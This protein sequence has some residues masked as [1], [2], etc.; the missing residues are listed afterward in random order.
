MT[1]SALRAVF[2]ATVACSSACGCG[3]WSGQGRLPDAVY[4][5][6]PVRQKPPSTVVPASHQ[7]LASA[8]AATPAV[9]NPQPF[10]GVPELDPDEVVRVVL[11]RNPTLDQMQA[12]V[13]AVAA[14]FPQVTSLDDPTF[15]F[16]TAP[17]SIGSP[18][19]DYA[20]RAEVS[21]KFISSAKRQLKGRSVQAETTAAMEDVEDLRTQLAESAKSALADY[22]LAVKSI[23]VVEENL[24]LI[25]DYRRNAETRYKTGQGQQQDMLQADVEIGRQEEQLL[26]LRRARQVAIAR[27]NTLMHFPPESLLPPPANG[28]A[29]ATLPDPP[30][31]RDLAQRRPD[32]RAALARI[33]AEEAQLAFAVKDYNPD[34]ELM[35]AYDGFWQGAGGR[36]LQWQAGMRMNLP[37]RYAKR[38]GIVHEARANIA[39]R[40]AELARLT[41]QVNYEVEEAF[42]RLREVKEITKLYDTK[43][44]PAAESNVKEA[45]AGYTTGKIPFLNL[46]EA[47]RNRIALQ[48][49]YYQAL[50]EV[51]RR[52]AALERAVGG[53]LPAPEK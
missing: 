38:S 26:S 53:K 23:K 34:I 8:V 12:T 51:M 31:L 20:A 11:A 33:G 37:V 48:E 28:P 41:D 42:E 21:Q 29:I 13:S 17:G 44:L 1:S 46:I 6:P 24:K 40:R 9:E 16:W 45:L 10:E 27:L 3:T 49:R 36:P 35:A 50:A 43:L 7:S 22:Y 14:R 4:P 39:R 30:E 25:R 18:N 47:Q 32:V 5:H 15:G 19:A 2:L 52:H